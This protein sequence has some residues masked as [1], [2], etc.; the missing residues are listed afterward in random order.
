MLRIGE[1]GIRAA[2]NEWNKAIETFKDDENLV[3]IF[4]IKCDTLKWILGEEK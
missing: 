1:E 2:L 4:T 3:K